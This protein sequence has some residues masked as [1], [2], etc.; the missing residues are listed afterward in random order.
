MHM[1][2]HERKEIESCFAAHEPSRAF[3]CSRMSK[4]VQAEL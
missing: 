4:S 2:V 3:R 1:H